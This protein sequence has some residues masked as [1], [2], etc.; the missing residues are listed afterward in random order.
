MSLIWADPS[1]ILKMNLLLIAVFRGEL[2]C[3][4]D[5]ASPEGCATRSTVPDKDIS[6][7]RMSDARRLQQQSHLLTLRGQLWWNLFICD[8]LWSKALFRLCSKCCYFKRSKTLKKILSQEN[9]LAKLLKLKQTLTPNRG[10]KLIKPSPASTSELSLNWATGI[11]NC[12]APSS[13]PRIEASWSG[14]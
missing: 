8:R 12:P 1:W 6:T 9:C 11:G 7:T 4:G 13:S 14:K 10:T 3:G 2:L 5:H